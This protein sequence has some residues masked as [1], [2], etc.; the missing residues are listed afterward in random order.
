MAVAVLGSTGIVGQYFTALLSIHPNFRVIELYAS[1]R[2]KGLLYKDAIDSWIPCIKASEEL[3]NMEVKSIEDAF[4]S[5]AELIFSALPSE[6]ARDF[7]PKLL[8]EGFTIVSNASPYRL[9]P[10]VPLINPEVNMSHIV[11]SEKQKSMW[12]GRLYK[13]PNCTTAI[14]TLTL[15]PLDEAYGIKRVFIT[16]MQSVSGA[17]LRGHYALEVMN[18][19]IPYI[20]GE[21]EKIINETRKILGRVDNGVI[22]PKNDI[23]VIATATRA[24]VIIGHTLSVTVELENKADSVEE[25]KEKLAEWR[26]CRESRK[27]YMT[28]KKP[29]V[30]YDRVDRPQPRL[31]SDIELGMTVAV[32]RVRVYSGG[33]IVSYVAVGN[34]LV[35]GAAGIAIAI[36]EYV[37]K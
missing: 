36:G 26:G 33:K 35:R 11:V 23:E 21:E 16:S 30:V 27:L 34:N 37:S 2:K 12:R 13:N 1:H 17:G 29:I 4:K 15:K 6:A 14:L 28:P 25:V 24:P 5:E 7:E 8:K 9:E 20:R 3:L 19:I 18:N 22:N 10:T 32:G 31:D